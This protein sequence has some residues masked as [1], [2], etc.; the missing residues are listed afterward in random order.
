MAGTA[1]SSG[2]QFVWRQGRAEVTLERAGDAWSVVYT[3]AG[4][5][6]GPRQ[7]LYRGN[8]R[9]MQHAAW[10]VMARVIRACRDEDEGL[11]VGRS[12]AQ[13]LRAHDIP[14]DEATDGWSG[15]GPTDTMERPQA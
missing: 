9:V 2:D 5:L 14:D 4:R 8:H 12:A 1:V 6:L 7:I 10:D 13:W 3:S 11:R 15:P